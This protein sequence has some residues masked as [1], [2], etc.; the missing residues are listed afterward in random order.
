ML[1]NRECL[2]G[3]NCLVGREGVWRFVIREV[4]ND[5]RCAGNSSLRNIE[6]S[7]G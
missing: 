5:Q 3:L 7:F 2:E 1:G 6:L 4:G